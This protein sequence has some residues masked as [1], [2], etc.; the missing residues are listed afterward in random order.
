MAKMRLC[1][2]DEC[3]LQEV[4]EV[5]RDKLEEIGIGGDTA[6]TINAGG[7][8]IAEFGMDESCSLGLKIENDG[9]K[10]TKEYRYV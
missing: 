9:D 6:V 1:S 10:V 3:E 2:K 8:I 4:L 7:N 5:L